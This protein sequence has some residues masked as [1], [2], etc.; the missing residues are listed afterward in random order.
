MGI[1]D[2]FAW[3]REA[4]GER[5]LP[6]AEGEVAGGADVPQ[7]GNYVGKVVR[8]R[9]GEEALVVSSV[10]SAVEI[11]TNSLAMMSVQYLKHDRRGGNYVVDDGKFGGRKLNYLL[12]VQPNGRQNAM[13]FWR[14]VWQNVV[15]KGNALLWIERDSS[16]EE[17]SLECA[18]KCASVNFDRDKNVYE[19]VDCGIGVYKK[20]EA[21]D[22]IHIKNTYTDETGLWGVPTIK[23]AARA[24]SVTA[25]ADS[26][27]LDT[28]SKGGRM[29]FIL[30]HGQKANLG[31]GR[32]SLKE[33]R[34]L[35][36]KLN[37]DIYSQD[38]SFLNSDG[39]LKQISL[40][41]ADQQLLQVREFGVSEVARFFGVPKSLLMDDSNSSYKTPSAANTA[42]LNRTLAPRI[43]ELE[44]ELNAKLLGIDGFGAHRIHV[45]EKDIFKMDLE[46][47]AAWNKSR[48]ETGLASVNELRKE[49]NM[50]VVVNGDDVM[51]STNLAAAGS[52]KIAD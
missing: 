17:L 44:L 43:R 20:L 52:S 48:L 34:K 35:A 49:A 51:V 29:K 21:K 3:K 22:V 26:Q 41:A 6:K 14:E 7:G 25:T 50:P 11:L 47:L 38:V 46:S 4:G 10:Y 18:R 39:E 5:V 8:I 1:F 40:S 42:F 32:Y 36:D 28:T 19:I 23:Y 33:N 27:T 30:M 12:Q 31:V 45:C 37:S 24:L 16:G 13:A 2:R 15:L 9:R